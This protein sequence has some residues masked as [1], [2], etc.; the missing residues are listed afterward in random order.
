[1]LSWVNMRVPD[2]QDYIEFMLYSNPPDKEQRGVKNHIC[3]IVPDIEKAVATLS[4]DGVRCDWLETS[5]AF[6]SA[7][8]D[9]ILDEFESYADRFDFRTPQRVLIDNRTGAALGW[10]VKLDGAYWRRHARQPAHEPG[11]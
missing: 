10:S 11:P 3:L 1:M 5:H 6:H 4:A 9:P 7:L 2:G 8:L